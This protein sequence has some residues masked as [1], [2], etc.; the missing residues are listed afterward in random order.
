MRLL[1]V[2]ASAPDTSL[3]SLARDQQGR[4]AAGTRIA[5]AGP[6]RIDL[7]LGHGPTLLVGSE[8]GTRTRFDAL[9]LGRTKVSV[10]TRLRAFNR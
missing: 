2:A 5:A 6:V 1:V 10:C 9:R 8:A 7:D 4:P 3:R